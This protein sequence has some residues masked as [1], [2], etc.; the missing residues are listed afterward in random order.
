MEVS[1]RWREG[2]LDRVL[3][4]RARHVAVH[5]DSFIVYG[6]YCKNVDVDEKDD[7]RKRTR[8]SCFQT[9]REVGSH[10]VEMGEMKRQGLAPSARAGASSAVHALKKRL[11]LF[12]GVVDHEV[13]RGDVIVSEFFTDA[14]NMNLEAKKW[15]PVT[16]TATI[17]RRRTRRGVSKRRAAAGEIVNE[18]FNIRSE[19]HRAA[20]KIQATPRIP[21]AQ[22]VQVVQGRRRRER[23]FILPWER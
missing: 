20:V 8:R 7:D 22:G 16:L 18:N 15:F 13:K 5:E 12:G 23:A 14:Y 10:A 21:S 9:L 4:A 2:A 17:R 1:A 19:A 3:G 11:V 6:G